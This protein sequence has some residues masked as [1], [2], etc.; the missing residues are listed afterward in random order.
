MERKEF[1]EKSL[2]FGLC[3]CALNVLNPLP[4]VGETET[5]VD[6]TLEQLKYENTF[7]KNWLSDLLDTMDK[8]L[9]KET[10][11]KVI[12]GCGRGC[13]NRHQFKKDIAEKG[14]GDVDKLI[15]AYKSSF[16]AW[17][18]GDTVHIRFGFGKGKKGCFCPTA[19]TQPVKPDDVMC[20][21]TRMTHQSI[22]ETALNRKVKIDILETVRRGGDV[23]HFLVHLNS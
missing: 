21:C 6:K 11:V 7:I 3:A 18:E 1:F 14:K 10:K 15:E 12:E 5:P 22:F 23:C 8:V 13:F 2:K 9:D 17:K 20:E 19:R 16:E 4:A